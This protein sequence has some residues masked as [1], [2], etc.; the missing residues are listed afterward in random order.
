[1]ETETELERIHIQWELLKNP[2]PVI[3]SHLRQSTFKSAIMLGTGA[4]MQCKD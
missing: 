2:E 1:M 3:C 4:S